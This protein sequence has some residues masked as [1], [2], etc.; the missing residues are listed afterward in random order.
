VDDLD[1]EASY[2]RNRGAPGVWGREEGGASGR[3][4]TNPPDGSVMVWLW[5]HRPR[6]SREGNAKINPFRCD[7]LPSLGAICPSLTSS[8]ASVRCDLSPPFEPCTGAGKQERAP[9]SKLLCAGL[10]SSLSQSVPSIDGHKSKLPPTCPSIRAPTTQRTSP[11]PKPSKQTKQACRQPLRLVVVAVRLP[12]ACGLTA[13]LSAWPC[14][15]PPK[16]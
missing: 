6:D 5:T 9:V 2:G 3:R 15:R 7:N 16:S 8:C 11:A 10:V 13:S 14:W 12:A 4:G 1:R